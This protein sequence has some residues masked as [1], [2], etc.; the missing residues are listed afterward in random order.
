MQKNETA[1]H[2]RVVSATV[3]R[4][5]LWWY[6]GGDPKSTSVCKLSLS[7]SLL[8]HRSFILSLRLFSLGQSFF[9]IYPPLSI[10]CLYSGVLVSL[11]IPKLNTADDSRALLAEKEVEDRSLY[12]YIVETQTM[13]LRLFLSL[14]PLSSNL[15]LLLSFFFNSLQ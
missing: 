13:T 9:F 3:D 15:F 2:C 10:L 8:L 7:F 14:V 6:D 11:T 1:R 4:V 12:I 5:V